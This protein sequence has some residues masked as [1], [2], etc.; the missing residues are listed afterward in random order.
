MKKKTKR[1]II[2]AA[3]LVV[4]AVAIIIF[5][6]VSASAGKASDTAYSTDIATKG[7][8]SETVSGSGNLGS[9]KT[10]SVAADSHLDI[11]EVLISAGDTLTAG[12]PI[13]S[14][15]TEAMQDYADDLKTTID[16]TQTQIDTTNNTTTK[17]SIK[18]PVDGWVKNVMLDED[19][20][21]QDAMSEYGYVA[22]VA[23]EER[24]IINAASS[25]LTEGT[26]VSVKCE[27]RTYDGNVTSENGTLYVS[28]DTVSRTVGADADYTIQ[29]AL[30][31]FQAR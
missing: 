7:D 31:S 21:I 12:Q 25:S 26:A 15:N 22:L 23:T 1:I 10:L 13:A 16:S 2:A 27:G 28:I 20:S 29:T 4:A 14:L 19:D 17:L 24:E 30:F 18:S 9:A 8:I 5:T 6:T 11:N 3:A